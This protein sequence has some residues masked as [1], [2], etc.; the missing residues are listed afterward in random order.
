MPTAVPS[1]RAR[2][3]KLLQPGADRVRPRRLV[4]E[5]AP[6]GGGNAEGLGRVVGHGAAGRPAVDEI[7][8]PLL[9]HLEDADHDGRVLGGL[10][11]GV[12]VDAA[13]ARDLVQER[14]HPAS[15]SR[16]GACSCR[17]CPG[18]GRRRGRSASS[19]RWSITSSPEA[20]G[21]LGGIRA[22]AGRRAGRPGSGAGPARPG[23]G[24]CPGCSRRRR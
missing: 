9:D 24:R 13:G 21:G 20:P 6:G 7:E 8:P 15:R 11:S 17:S 14:G 5:D 22:Y 4:E 10:R 12:V 3:N 18:P 23:P 16:P 1:L 2:R 19:G